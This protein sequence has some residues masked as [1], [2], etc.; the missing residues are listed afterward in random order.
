MAENPVHSFQISPTLKR[1]PVLAQDPLQAWDSA[2][3]LLLQHLSSLDLKEKRIL[4]VNDRFGALATSLKKCGIT[5]FTDSFV[6]YKAS[7]FNTEGKVML[8]NNFASFTGVYDFVLIKLPPNLSFFEDILCH[9]TPHLAPHSQLICGVMIKHLSKGSF[10]LLEKYI[11]KTHTSLA[12]KK[13]RLIFASF[14]KGVVSSPYPL[15]VKIES[16]HVPFVN[17]SNLFSREKLDIGTRFFLEHI[18]AGNHERVLD[19]GCAN[20]II[21]IRA[22][23]KNPKATIFFSDDSYQAIQSAQIN[24]ANFFP[25]EEARFFWTHCFESGEP[26][27]LDLVLCNPPFHQQTTVGDQI[28][29]QMFQDSFRALKKNGILR[30]VGNTHLQYA[31]KLKKIFGNSKIVATHPKFVIVDARK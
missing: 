7:E 14:E 25:D 20:G 17:Y 16:F 24:H 4:L 3:E 26:E 22:K 9:L 27:S 1:Y 23:E 6:S 5:S 29:W 31:S 8:V 11:G 18:P 19:L 21:G 10:D 12:Q 15:Q 13:A 28:A 2:D 30:I